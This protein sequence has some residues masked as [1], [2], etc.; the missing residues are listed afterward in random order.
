MND[1]VKQNGDKNL[2]IL[3]NTAELE[4]FVNIVNVVSQTT[5]QRKEFI[6][7]SII[8]GRALGLDPLTAYTAF[9]DMLKAGGGAELKNSALQS[10]LIEKSNLCEPLNV[11]RDCEPEYYYY[12]SSLLPEEIYK[13]YFKSVSDKIFNG[14]PPISFEAFITS[15]KKVNLYTNPTFSKTEKRTNFKVQFQTGFVING[16]PHKM[17]ELITELEG[18]VLVKGKKITKRASYRLSI[19][20]NLGLFFTK[21]GKVKNAWQ[22]LPRMMYKRCSDILFDRLA[23]SSSVISQIDTIA[24]AEGLT[25][26][27]EFKETSETTES[28]EI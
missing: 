4:N 19:A 28:N 18:T 5:G 25:D 17:D 6:A 11:I 15:V 2:Q 8:K 23:L 26:S 22:N 24:R 9:W 3:D 7:E 1:L 27:E 16:N 20:V 14:K 10:L 12:D 13:D 21:D